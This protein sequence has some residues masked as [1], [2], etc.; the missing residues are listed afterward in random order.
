[1]INNINIEFKKKKLNPCL[2]DALNGTGNNIIMIYK[3][4]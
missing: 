2:T 4:G 1:M 3:Y